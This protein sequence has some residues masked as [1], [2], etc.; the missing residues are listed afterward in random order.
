MVKCWDP[1]AAATTATPPSDSSP[2]WACSRSANT[3]FRSSKHKAINFTGRPKQ[4][5]QTHNTHSH[6]RTLA[7]G[8]YSGGGTGFTCITNF[9]GQAWVRLLGSLL[10]TISTKG[11]GYR[12]SQEGV[13]GQGGRKGRRRRRAYTAT[14]VEEGHN[15]DLNNQ[16][17]KPLAEA[18]GAQVLP[19]TRDRTFGGEHEEF[20]YLEAKPIVISLVSPFP[21]SPLSLCPC[22]LWL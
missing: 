15:C 6:L 1:K 22:C 12:Q 19:S 7:Q 3:S 4:N 18:C 9:A 2:H 11:R 20:E 17:S 8:H 5:C 21:H 10:W 13:G 14:E 16:L